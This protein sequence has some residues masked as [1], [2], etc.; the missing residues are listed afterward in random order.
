[1]ESIGVATVALK[2]AMHRLIAAV[3]SDLSLI[4]S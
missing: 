3:Y 1:M 4:G 2:A